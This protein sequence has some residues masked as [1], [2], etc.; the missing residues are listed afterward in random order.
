MTGRNKQTTIT[1][2]LDV[3]YDSNYVEISEISG[4]LAKTLRG[5]SEPHPHRTATG[6]AGWWVA[7]AVR[8][9]DEAVEPIGFQG[10]AT[11]FDQ[12]GM[13]LDEFDDGGI[14]VEDLVA[15]LREQVGEREA[16]R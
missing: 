13:A 7:A 8:T 2:Q 4:D 9:F 12:L 14:T 1:V 15:V 5:I 16:N 11:S 6:D 10:L 3:E